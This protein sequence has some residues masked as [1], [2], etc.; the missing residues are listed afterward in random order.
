MT[1][2][3]IPVARPHLNGKSPHGQPDARSRQGDAARP[4]APDFAAF[5][6]G[7]E[8]P[9]PTPAL[10]KRVLPRDGL[11]MLGGKSGAGKSYVAVHLAI[12][13]AAMTPWFGNAPRMQSNVLY[14]AAE[15]GPNMVPRIA[16][17]KKA[18]GISDRLPIRVIRRA[19]FPA[20]DEEFAAYVQHVAS[21]V[22]AMRERTKIANTVIITD[23]VSAAFTL[24]D[25][26][27][28][29]D[30]VKLCKRA[31]AIGDACQAL[32]IL[33]HHF[34]KDE[35]RLFRGSSAWR[36]N[37]DH[38]FSIFTERANRTAET[39]VR[40]INIE[41][42]RMG[43][44]G[45]L[46][47]FTLADMPI[48]LD[49]DGDEWVE[50]YVRPVDYKEIVKDSPDKADMSGKTSK[51]GKV[52][53]DSFNH[54]LLAK[55][56]R[57]SVG[58]GGPGQVF[59]RAVRLVDV[60]DEFYRRYPSDSPDTISKAWRREQEAIAK[61]GL[62]YA[63]ERDKREIAWMWRRDMQEDAQMSPSDDYS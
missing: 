59:V 11:V 34:G 52:L 23:T 6:D 44:E 45:K 3:S 25:E 12:C 4:Q 39:A 58:I 13:L 16:A 19:A 22:K 49:E 1:Y 48:G 18:A 27:A 61:H 43:P 53:R 42:S 47:G 46:S 41:K 62:G 51:A 54:A 56:A 37:I 40:N 57:H 31:R 30:V 35:E 38:G 9:K 60:R 32:H 50:A 28:A 7:E 15:G 33:V 5:W 24:E 21:E 2:T 10:I 55:G 29:S 8:Q 26:N 36:D 17:A 14:I 63:T 20:G